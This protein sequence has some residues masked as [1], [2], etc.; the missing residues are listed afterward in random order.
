MFEIGSTLAL[1]NDLVVDNVGLGRQKLRTIRKQPAEAG[2]PIEGR[3]VRL[4]LACQRG[5][6]GDRDC[7]A[8]RRQMLP[9]GD[10]KVLPG[11]KLDFGTA[12]LILGQKD[13]HFIGEPGVDHFARRATDFL[14]ILS[15]SCCISICAVKPAAFEEA[16]AN[17]V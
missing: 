16:R 7:Q 2:V 12:D 4:E 10:V 3:T 17:A 14:G 15:R 6:Q 13:F 8:A 9:V 5:L 1:D 11:G